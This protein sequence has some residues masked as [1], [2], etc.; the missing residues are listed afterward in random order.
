M[1][2]TLT[3]TFVIITVL[4][5]LLAFGNPSV[6]GAAI[7]YPFAIRQRKE[8]Y[9]FITS[10]FIHADIIH[11]AVNMY[12]LYS[13]GDLLEKVYFPAVF[14]EKTK[15][16]FLLLYVG[17]LIISDIPSYFRHR[18][19]A[20]YRALGASGAVS[21][22][23]FACIL[24]GPFDGGIGLLFIPIYLPPVIF[25]ALYLL[26]SMFMSRAGHDNINHDAHFFGAVWGLLFPVLL[27]PE[28][29]TYFIEQ[30]KAQL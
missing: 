11:L 18:Y 23:V 7:F 8:Y 20:S 6:M 26:Y 29:F 14:G 19:N 9:R 13:F 1:Q 25:G 15:L 3:L 30:I 10:G 5:S 2:I 24:L 12:V 27:K 28:L 4:T 22:V 21:S 17:G 16:Y